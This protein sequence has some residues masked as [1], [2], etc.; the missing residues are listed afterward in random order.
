MNIIIIWSL[1][2]TCLQY[3]CGFLQV[4]LSAALEHLECIFSPPALKMSVSDYRTCCV[5]RPLQRRTKLVWRVNL[6]LPV[7]PHYHSE[8]WLI[9]LRVWRENNA[10]MISSRCI[11]NI[12]MYYILWLHNFLCSCLKLLYSWHFSYLFNFSLLISLTKKG[13]PV[14]KS[15]E[16]QCLS[17]C[18]KFLLHKFFISGF[19]HVCNAEISAGFLN[20]SS[21]SFSSL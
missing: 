4:L 7:C 15:G 10:S 11:I 13:F 16:G 17:S 20:L 18:A 8:Q 1:L 14:Q 6:W 5:T 19:P 3:T 21:F 2:Y 9:F 12:V